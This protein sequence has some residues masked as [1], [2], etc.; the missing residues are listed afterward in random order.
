MEEGLEEIR[1]STLF[2]GTGSLALGQGSCEY[3][4]IDLGGQNRE[5]NAT[6]T[7]DATVRKAKATID[8]INPQINLTSWQEVD[9]F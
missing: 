4:V 2:S 3:N 5:I 1:E 7:V 6:G 9:D 8:T